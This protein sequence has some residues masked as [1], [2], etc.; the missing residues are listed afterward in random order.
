MDEHRCLIATLTDGDLRRAVLNGWNLDLPVAALVERF[1]AQGKTHPISLPID[2]PREAILRS[3]KSHSV[4]Q[5]PLVDEQGQ[6]CDLAVLDD[7]VGPP[8]PA[9]HA[10]VMAGGYGKRL[11]P[12]TADTP[13]PLLRI[14]DK[15]LIQRLVQQLKQAG[16]SKVNISTHYKAE[17]ISEHLGNGETFGVDL[18]YVS[19]QQPLGTAGGL[20]LVSGE[21]PL[22]VV[23]G[24]ILTALDFRTLFNFHFE[25]GAEMTVA[26]REYGFEVPYGVVET[27]GVEVTGITEKPAV[28]FFVNAG[29]YL[30]SPSAR[31]LI[32][33]GQPFDMPQLID[34]L[35]RNGRRVISFPVWEY[36]LDIGRPEDY[37]RAQQEAPRLGV[38]N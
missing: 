8:Q 30:V 27:N 14:G 12:L 11:M 9:V 38:A 26:V 32:P 20:S 23:N 31:Q 4:R 24:D 35:V 37:E 16:I 29:I 5:I 10:V 28:K 15:P 34:L 7:L 21:D 6:V 13:K 3:M 25:Q 18:V 17:Q 19:E 33:P 1:R 22:L 36:W 2:C